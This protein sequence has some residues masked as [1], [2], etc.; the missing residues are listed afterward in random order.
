MVPHRIALRVASRFC[1]VLP[2]LVIVVCSK[3]TPGAL[4]N[5]PAEIYLPPNG[6]QAAFD[7]IEKD[8]A[9]FGAGP[10]HDAE[11]PGCAAPVTIH[12][13]GLT[14]DISG[15]NGP[16]HMRIV[17]LIHNTSSKAVDHTPSGT[18]FQANTKYLMWVASRGDKK[19][20]WGFIELGPA[21]T[22]HP[23]PI[24]LLQ[25]CTHPKPMP[26]STA[27]DAAFKTCDDAYTSRSWIKSAYAS[28]PTYA[29]IASPTW[30]AC[31][32]DCCTGTRIF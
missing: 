13:T 3:P 4:K 26:R 1:L 14:T 17:A 6:S 31:D 2:L 19:A 27:D 30:V 7:Q 24:G 22:S 29:T 16:A 23:K 20:V 5:R 28:P 9:Q 10:S 8:L 25:N 11:C 18:T 15:A 21:Y 12:S 32:P